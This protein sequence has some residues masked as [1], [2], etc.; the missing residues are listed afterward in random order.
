MPVP[1]ARTIPADGPVAIVSGFLTD[2]ARLQ[3]RDTAQAAALTETAIDLIASAAA[4]VAGQPLAGPGESSLT[5]EGVLAYVRANYTDPALSIDALAAAC[6]VSRRSVY[7]VFEE[8][9]ESPTDLLRRLR[10]RHACGMLV[11]R[12][13]LTFAAIGA[14]S[15][16]ATERQF[17]RAFRRE[18]GRTPGEY[19]RFG[20]DGQSSG[21]V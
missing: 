6:F 4:L 1:A 20:T 7:R 3:D 9:G 8:H 12:P 21:T 14:A 17:Y 11:S 5:R 15:G 2:L 10:V 13:D 18:T 16:F 19:R